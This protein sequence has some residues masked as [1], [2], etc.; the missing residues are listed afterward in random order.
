MA[1]RNYSGITVTGKEAFGNNK[2]EQSASDYISNKS[3][4]ANY[5][6]N[7]ICLPRTSIKD[8]SSYLLLKRAN[9][10]KYYKK[11]DEI[12]AIKCSLPSGLITTIQLKDIVVIE[13]I[14]GQ[15]PTTISVTSLPYLDYIIDPSG[16]LFG[17]TVCGLNNIMD[18]RVFND[19]LKLNL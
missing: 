4:K 14:E 17:D 2:Q 19:T 16:T 13:N 8:Q 9:Y 7:R 18:H 1:S 11:I 5:C 15:T 6:K 3:A 12:R 10:L